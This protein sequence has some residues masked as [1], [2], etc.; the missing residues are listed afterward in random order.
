MPTVTIIGAGRAGGALALALIRA[1]VAVEQLVYHRMPPELF[2]DIPSNTKLSPWTELS[3]VDSDIAIIAS[4]DP[5]I[6]PIGE[7]ISTF[8][9][10]P[11]IALHLSGARDSNELVSLRSKGVAVGS[12]HPL[13]SISEPVLGSER[14]AG[15]YFCIEGDG[16]AVDTVRWLVEVLGGRHF[17]IATEHKPLYHASAVMA[18]GHV[19]ALIDSAI[20][21]L[22]ACGLEENDAKKV[23]IP[24]IKSTIANIEQQS[25]EQA[26]TGPFARGDAE[27]VEKHLKAMEE[28]VPDDIR[29]IYLD[30]GERSVSILRTASDD[31]AAFYDL[32][33]LISMAKAQGR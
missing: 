11:K 13:V 20:G 8:E 24:L 31:P 28:T 21:M 27:T 33:N 19:T 26:L 15:A 29:Q 3:G 7:S 32:A 9:K 4:A 10:L 30:L 18:S 12:M 1:G 25:S 5:E 6:R 22:S 17:A 2:F 16:M 14:F 23:L